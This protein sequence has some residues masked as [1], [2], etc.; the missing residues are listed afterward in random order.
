MS[1]NNELEVDQAT[2]F[3]SL[4]DNLLFTLFQDTKL[5]FIVL[6]IFVVLIY[7]IIFSMVGSSANDTTENTVFGKNI[8]VIIL[9][10]LLWISLIVV[11]Y[12]NIKNY[13]DQNYDFQ[14]SLENLFDSKLSELKINVQGSGQTGQTGQTDSSSNESQESS[15]S[16]C[17]EPGDE[18]GK[19]V[20]HIAENKFTY[21]EARDICKRYGARLATYDEIER[22]YDDGAN[23]CNYGWSDDQMIFYPTQK[24]VYN[25]LKKMP[26]HK[27]SC[28]RPG[29]NGGYIENDQAK[30][31]ANCYGYRPNPKEIDRH[32]MHSI[33]HTPNVTD[34]D[35][36]NANRQANTISNY[37]V[38]PFNKEKW[39]HQ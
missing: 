19:E 9:E 33:N 2:Q 6:L 3:P 1:E 38:A 37:I 24:K 39:A 12:V 34:E 28:G 36:A 7:V 23:W 15:P 4:E 25:L 10:L 32:Y 5:Y 8:T 20:F 14:A 35:I 29:I 18:S 21:L 17:P 26:E 16:S 22:A 30:F 31:G 13:S 11:I 27:N